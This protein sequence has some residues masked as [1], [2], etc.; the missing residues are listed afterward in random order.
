MHRLAL[1][2]ALH[3]HQPVG[4]FDHVMA[5]AADSA[6]APMVAALERHPRVRLALHYSG[7]LLDWLLLHRPDLLRRIRALAGRGQA[8]IMTGGY[9]EPILAIIPEADRR[10]QIEKLTRMVAA[11]FGHAAEG[12]WLA[13]RVWEPH[14]ARSLGEAGVLYTIV[15]DAHFHGV[16][17]DDPQLLGYYVTED[18]GVPLAIFPSLRRLRYLIPWAPVEDVI[19][20]LHSL[21]DSDVRPEGREAPLDLALMGDDGEKFGLWP[22]TYAHCWEKG[23]VER[24][25]EAI[26]TEPWIDLIP[27]GEYRRSREPAGWIYLPTATYQEMTEWALPPERAAQLAHI[28]HDLENSGRAEV[29]PFL[30]GGF[31]RHFL[32]KYPE[33]N[34]LHHLAL[35]AGRKVRAMTAG[36]ERARALDELWAGE[37]NCTYWHG[38]FG[39]VYLPHLRGAAFSH[40]IAAEAIAD[41]ARHR[42]PYVESEVADLNGD[43]RE[44]VRL[45]TDLAVCT[46]DPA[47]GGSLAEWD[48]RPARRHLGNVL[49]RRPEGYHADLRRAAEQGA[50]RADGAAGVESIHTTAVRLKEPGLE[51]FLLYDRVS[52]ASLRIHLLP[53]RTTREQVWR[54]DQSELGA[55]FTGGYAWRLDQATD[56]VRL[57][58]TRRTALE[59]G[60]A[61][62]ERTLEVAAGRRGLSHA[63]RVRWTGERPLRALLAEEWDLGVFGEPGSIY[64]EG[65]GRRVPLHEPGDLT[66]ARRVDVVETHSG[67]GLAFLPSAPADVWALPLITISNSEAGFERNYQGAMVLLCW[68]LEVASGEVW[69][70]MTRC[71]VA[72]TGGGSP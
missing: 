27:P 19:A 14:L 26:E 12:L 52:R 4:N 2:L 6:Y 57:V 54:D 62:V 71:E 5:E 36:P 17:L 41:Q 28:R 67:L 59:G 61:A 51:R 11:E 63:T 39:G 21:A 72:V 33:V 65:A 13:E 40:L 7:P 66:A 10:G 53:P 29:L 31:W 37:G 8:E 69:E 64:L 68:K 60:E 22:G 30:R 23:W 1:S 48:D 45:A 32:V 25:F 56:R 9:Y 3:N 38:V 24:F 15:D 70:Q 44:E 49:T 18:E 46:V 55:F 16:G 50:A 58:L 47:R 34:T 35:R 43:G 42:G 20:Y